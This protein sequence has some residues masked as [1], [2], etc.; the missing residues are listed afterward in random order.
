MNKLRKQLRPRPRP[1]PLQQ[2]RNLPVPKAP[3]AE[4]PPAWHPNLQNVMPD[5][6]PGLFEQQQAKKAERSFTQMNMLG[7]LYASLR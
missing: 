7:L 4:D 6:K 3:D 2:D 5:N 1:T